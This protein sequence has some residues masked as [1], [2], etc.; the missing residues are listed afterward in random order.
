[1]IY[2]KNINKHNFLNTLKNTTFKLRKINYIHSTLALTPY[3]IS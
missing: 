2:E 3:T 1:M